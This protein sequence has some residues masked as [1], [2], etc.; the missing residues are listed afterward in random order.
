MDQAYSK[1]NHDLEFIFDKDAK[2]EAEADDIEI[3]TVKPTPKQPFW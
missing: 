3:A 2:V 1:C